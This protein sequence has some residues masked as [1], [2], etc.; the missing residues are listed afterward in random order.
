MSFRITLLVAIT[1]LAG[2]TGHAQ[3]RSIG[4]PQAGALRVGQ[5]AEV[6]VPAAGQ[7]ESAESALPIFQAPPQEGMAL[8]GAPAQTPDA[9]AAEIT[10]SQRIESMDPRNSEVARVAGALA[11]VLG[12]LLLLRAGVRRFGGPLSGGGRPSGVLEVIGRYPVARAQ[13]LLL[14]KIGRRVVLLHQSKGGMTAL[15]EVG[16]PDEVA[17]LLARIES[18]ERDKGDG[19]FQGTLK[20]LM[21][22]GSDRDPGFPPDPQPMGHADRKVV[23][24]LTRRPHRRA[25]GRTGGGE[26]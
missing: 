6:S 9:G 13:H 1:L 3:E 11:L 25:F 4:S 18:A 20:R 12:L 23:I 22:A 24:D 19:R 10:V 15:S 16:D 8:G 26:P 17:S 7:T 21:G 2:R 5:A 14:L